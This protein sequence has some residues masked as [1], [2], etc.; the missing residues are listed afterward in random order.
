VPQPG[1][2]LVT[3]A[4]LA[5]MVASIAGMRSLLRVVRN[6]S[7][8]VEKHLALED[9]RQMLYIKRLS[10]VSSREPCRLHLLGG[11]MQLLAYE[12]VKKKLL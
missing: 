2:K 3:S 10:S 9:C 8:R 12:K 6:A 4:F 7:S 1:G 11:L 5:R